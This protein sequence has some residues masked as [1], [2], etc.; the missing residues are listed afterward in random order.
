MPKKKGLTKESI[1]SFLEGTGWIYRYARRYRKTILLYIFLG[2][3]STFFGLA[4]SVISKQL[5]DA[6]VA[7]NKSILFWVIALYIGFNVANLLMMALTRRITARLDI[8]ASNEIRADVFEQFLTVDWQSSL[9]YHSGDLLTRV[10]NDVST[11]SSGILGWIPSFITGSV[12]LIATL[13][14]ILSYDPIMA[15]I[16]LLGAPVTFI[17]SRFL[18]GRMQY[19]GHRVREAQASL[20]AFSEESLQ[21]L[22]ATK[23]FHLN[24]KF[25]HRLSKLQEVY[26]DVSIE[27]TDF[28]VLNQ[29]I[30]SVIGF[31]VSG[32][33]LA[34]SVYCLWRG[35]I[36]VGTLVLF[37]QLA[38]YAAGSFSSLISLVPSAVSSSVS[39]GRIMT[40]LDLPSE[41]HAVSEEAQSVL[42]QAEKDG[43]AIEIDHVD[44]AYK[45]GEAVLQDFSF[46]ANPGEIIGIVSPSGG[47]KTTLIR[48]LLGL[49]TPQTG[50]VSL[51]SGSAKAVLSPCLQPL[52]TY[53]A[54]EKVVFSGTVADSLRLASPLASDE[55]LEAALKAACAE[56]FVARMP[57]G[58]HSKLGERGSGLSEGQIQRLAIARA[59]VS[60]A[61]IMLLDEATSALD[62]ETEKKVLHNMLKG[63]R[64][65]TVIVTTHRPTVLLSCDRVYSIEDGRAVQLTD[66]QIE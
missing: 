43:V 2:L 37:L 28:S 62:L 38:R 14:V 61:P 45:T 33:C 21:N 65:R 24:K 52:T 20:T 15:L 5:I 54:Q 29:F 6:V 32:M 12:Q 3:L 34:W 48:M 11:V 56:R 31:G 13:L 19:L 41:D 49:V 16:A 39:A 27:S 60:H 47:G 1:H 22:Q 57:Q 36:S 66:E 44:F 63:D 59:L 42:A 40:V 55:E 4:G 9:E 23:A 26:R 51:C 35:N 17:L 64:Q 8:K 30:L 58:I 53:V 7:H 50:S 25:N 18:I 46:T 10:N